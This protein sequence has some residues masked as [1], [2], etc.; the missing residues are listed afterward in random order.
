[1]TVLEWQPDPIAELMHRA[2]EPSDGERLAARNRFLSRVDREL[3]RSTSTMLIRCGATLTIAAS[4]LLALFFW[5][6]QRELE[7]TVEGAERDGNYVRAE[8]DRPAE[9]AFSDGT[10]IHAAAGARLRTNDEDGGNGVG[11][12]VERGRI[13]VEVPHAE[14]T[15]WRFEAG[16]F[17]MLVTGTRFALAWDPDQEKLEVVLH[18]GTVEVQGYASSGVVTV[19]AG[20]RFVGDARQRT[21]LVTDIGAPREVSDSPSLAQRRSR[22]RCGQ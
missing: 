13:E 4:V 2:G 3:G 20:Q 18:A 9:I 10:R 19:N 17:Q 7:Y 5:P 22:A 21:M 16:P 1:M 6:P 11:V 14:S 8:L 12:A 15:S